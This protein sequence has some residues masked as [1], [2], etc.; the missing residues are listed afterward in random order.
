MQSELLIDKSR[1]CRLAFEQGCHPRFAPV[2][3]AAANANLFSPPC[4]LATAY[5]AIFKEQDLMNR[6]LR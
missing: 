3:T 4:N 6:A 5:M 2:S 1:D